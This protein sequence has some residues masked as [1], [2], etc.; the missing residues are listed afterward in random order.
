MAYLYAVMGVVMMTGIMAIFELG[1]SLTGQSV[2]PA[3][4]DPY[5]LTPQAKALDRDLLKLLADSNAV[6]QGLR[7][8]DLCEAIRMAYSDSSSLNLMAIESG[9]FD[10]G[11]SVEREFV[12]TTGPVYHRVLIQPS[13]LGAE[14]LPYQ[15]FSCTTDRKNQQ[16]SFERG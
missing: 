13:D 4:P 5:F 3:L 12:I 15:L 16:C 6:S 11:C 1:L 9:R 10:G 7:L 8:K 14:S 2:L